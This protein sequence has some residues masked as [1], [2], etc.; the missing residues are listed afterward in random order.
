MKAA[1]TLPCNNLIYDGFLFT[2]GSPKIDTGGLNT[3][4]PHQVGKQSDIIVL[5]KEILCIPMPEGMGIYHLL[6]QP[7]F[8]G[9]VFQ[10][11]G[12]TPCGDAFAEAV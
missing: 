12:N 8:L 4:V 2:G 6:V 3:F 7:I 9:I 5:L 10:L 11:L 1:F